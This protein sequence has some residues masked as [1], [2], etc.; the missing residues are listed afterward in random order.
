MALACD[1]RYTRAFLDVP[2]FGQFPLRAQ[3]EGWKCTGSW[4]SL[5]LYKR[6]RPE[7]L[8]VLAYFDSAVAARYITTPVLA[9]CALFDPAV[10]PAGQFAVYNALHGHK[11][12]FVREAGHFAGGGW[13]GEVEEQA[14]LD[15]RIRQWFMK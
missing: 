4:E 7:I 14:R 1:K 9:A 11:E 6:R 13:P 3:G 10:A 5:R 12:L 2:A 15:A 8:D